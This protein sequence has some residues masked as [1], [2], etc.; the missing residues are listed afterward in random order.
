VICARFKFKFWNVYYLCFI[1]IIYFFTSL[2]HK[3]AFSIQ[4]SAFSIQHSAFRWNYVYLKNIHF[5]SNKAM[6]SEFSNVISYWSDEN[7]DSGV[8]F[9]LSS[10]TKV[11]DYDV[12]WVNYVYFELLIRYP[13]FL[14]YYIHILSSA[15]K[16]EVVSKF[17]ILV[18]YSFKF[19]ETSDYYT[20]N[21]P[22]PKISIRFSF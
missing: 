14:K 15:N 8:Y 16:I 5:T 1:S 12:N 22:K 9:L 7:L 3:T 10:I 11:L 19:V 18:R 2:N 20:L 21:L 6:T 17:Y 4:H 13:L